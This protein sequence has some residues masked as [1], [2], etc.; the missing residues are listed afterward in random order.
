[1]ADVR[2]T[3]GLDASAY[4]EFKKGID[5]IVKQINSDPP[6]IKVK[7]DD[8]NMDAMRKQIEML[9]KAQKDQA[10]A[11][12]ASANIEIGSTKQYNALR[13]V[14]N[15]LTQVTLN[16]Q[17]WTAAQRG[18]T[19]TQFGTYS[20]AAGDLKTLA[21]QLEQGT[22]SAQEFDNKFAQIRASMAETSGQIKVAGEATGAMT[23]LLSQAAANIVKFVGVYK[24]IS[25]GIRVFKEMA[26]VSIEIES[27]MAQ[28][29][30]VTGATGA[31]LE[32]FFQTSTSLA[33]EL[34]QSITD[35]AKSIE[36]FSRLGFRL[37]DASS[38]AEYA[39]ILSNVADTD[40]DAATTGMTSIIKG[41]DMDVSNAEHVADVLTKVGQAYAIS[42]EE[43]MT[44]FERGGASMYAEG[45]SFEKSAALF[46][47]TNASLKLWRAA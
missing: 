47:A 25:T 7:F 32:G 21:T 38:L 45:T 20:Q 10:A 44:A 22:I 12:K 4:S 2:L 46:A 17:K 13:Q 3:I 29:Q 1:M 27:A 36:T 14:N 5:D 34:G 15:A 28:I 43:L 30:V 9:T 41:Y 33:K 35:V 39:T 16:T 6:K 23:N 19:Q 40:I 31:E 37:E 11:A 18:Q 42:A 24:L 26:S 8:K